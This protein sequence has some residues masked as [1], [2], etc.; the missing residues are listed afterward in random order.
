MGMPLKSVLVTGLKSLCVILL[1]FYTQVFASTEFDQ[2]TEELLSLQDIIERCE[3]GVEKAKEKTEGFDE[4]SF[5]NM[6][7]VTSQSLSAGGSAKLA[8]QANAAINSVMA[9]NAVRRCNKCK[10]AI[11]ECQSQCDLEEQC[12]R[13]IGDA[14]GVCDSS[15]PY[16]GCPLVG[17]SGT[18][19]DDVCIQDCNNKFDECKG[20]LEEGLEEC[21]TY[22]SPCNDS[23]VQAGLSGLTALTSLLA[24]EQLGGNVDKAN[25]LPKK[26]EKKDPKLEFPKGLKA[27]DAP[28]SSGFADSGFADGEGSKAHSPALFSELQGDKSQQ[29]S[30][31]TKTSV[32][33]TDLS[34]P[35]HYYGRDGL[36][37]NGLSKEGGFLGD[38]T[39]SKLDQFG[40]SKLSAD[41]NDSARGK[42]SKRRS[43]DRE[44]EIRLAQQGF[45]GSG[46]L[47]EGSSSHSARVSSGGGR[48]YRPKAK[49]TSQRGLSGE[50]KSSNKRDSSFKDNIF[51]MTSHLIFQFCDNGKC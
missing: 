46:G 18:R 2:A 27:S 29:A 37:R 42:K 35:R 12:Q 50:A 24:A 8:H 32:E 44:E 31:P 49:K 15:Q 1:F 47:F 28:G 6:Q 43:P 5:N 30:D 23:C 13:I 10:V 14:G 33:P 21:E 45:S 38:T 39:G 22:K 4:T 36:S 25:L 41:K 16:Y 48:R 17:L 40:S 3:E 51:G 26:E 9:A 19:P 20:S 7:Q 11:N 34:K